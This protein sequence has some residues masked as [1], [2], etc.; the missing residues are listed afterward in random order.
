MLIGHVTPYNSPYDATIQ[1]MQQ[2]LARNAASAADALHQAQAQLCAM[3]QRQALVLSFIDAFWLLAVIFA[4]MLALVLLLRK[5]D[6]GS[7]GLSAH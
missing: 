5:P 3:M 7:T 4:G 6:P 2:A 1:V